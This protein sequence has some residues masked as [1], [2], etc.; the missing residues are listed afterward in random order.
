MSSGTREYIGCP[1]V[2][3]QE[4]AAAPRGRHLDLWLRL[5]GP[6]VPVRWSNAL[7]ATRGSWLG[8]LISAVC[9]SIVSKVFYLAAPVLLPAILM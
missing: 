4:V 7:W 3:Q 1:Q 6:D 8:I 9:I 2:V 5:P